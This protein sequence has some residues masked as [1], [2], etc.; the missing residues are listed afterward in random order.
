[1]FNAESMFVGFQRQKPMW[2]FASKGVQ[3]LWF[4]RFS[5][6]LAGAPCGTPALPRRRARSRAASPARRPLS[7]AAA[8]CLQAPHQRAVAAKGVQVHRECA[9]QACLACEA[10]TL[11]AAAPWLQAPD[12]CMMLSRQSALTRGCLPA[13]AH[14]Q[15][16]WSVVRPA[17]G[18]E[19]S[20]K[21]RTG[22][23]CLAWVPVWRHIARGR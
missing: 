16:S 2:C 13:M 10:S 5:H 22:Y 11:C 19:P 6:T 4:G 20:K 12:A 9:S 7:R 17:A 18:E 15:R 8:H 1:M 3:C 23:K 21:T 14:L